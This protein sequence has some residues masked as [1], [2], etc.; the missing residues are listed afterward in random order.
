MNK[1]TALKLAEEALE[2]APIEY[3]FHGEPVDKEFAVLSNKALAAIREALA[4]PVKQEPMAFADKYGNLYSVAGKLALELECLLLD[5]ED[6]SVVSKWWDSAHDALEQWRSIKDT[7]P[8]ERQ[9]VDLTDD[10]L[11]AA[12]VEIDASTVRLPMGLSCLLVQSSPLSRRRTSESCICIC[13]RHKEP[14]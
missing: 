3:D 8:V 13:F 9:W 6:L 4:Q 5:T 11:L 12:L 14:N 10:E 1:I 7:A 2:T